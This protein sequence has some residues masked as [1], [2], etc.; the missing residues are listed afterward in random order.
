MDIHDLKSIVAALTGKV[1]YSQALP[2]FDPLRADGEKNSAC[3]TFAVDLLRS[4]FPNESIRELT[5]LEWEMV[6]HQMTPFAVLEKV[7]TLSFASLGKQQSE[8]IKGLNPVVLS[9]LK[10]HEMFNENPVY[11]LGAVVFVGSQIRDYYNE[12]IFERA[13]VARAHAYEAEYLITMR[14]FGSLSLNDY[15]ENILEKYP[16]GLASLPPG[17]QYQSKPWVEGERSGITPK[18]FDLNSN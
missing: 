17:V 1:Q 7:P 13:V 15:Q 12:K 14:Q 18:P 10:W 8:G 16:A 5:A 4:T 3:F 2:F 9:P 6:G 11:Q